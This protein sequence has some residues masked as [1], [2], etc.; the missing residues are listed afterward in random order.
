MKRVVLLILFL[1]G[2]L[3]LGPGSEA[4]DRTQPDEASSLPSAE[5]PAEP[6]VDRGDP[7]GEP[8][9]PG[10][11]HGDGGST[12]LAS[13]PPLSL[14]GQGFLARSLT[15]DAGDP[16]DDISR[17]VPAGGWWGKDDPD[18]GVW[19]LRDLR[20]GIGFTID[21]DIFMIAFGLGFGRGGPLELAPLV[22]LGISDDELLVAP[23][24]N[25]VYGFDLTE[26]SGDRDVQRLTPYV[27]GGVGMTYLEKERPGGR[28]D[29]DTGLLFDFGFGVDY[30]V[31]DKLSVGTSILFNLLPAE[32]S[33]EHFFVSWQLLSLRVAF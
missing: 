31:G 2:G 1:A 20:S 29:A 22:Q 3:L 12:L 15:Q 11:G 6:A 26:L 19:A 24:L 7:G 23:A 10:D 32:L 9:A 21:P 17:P 18:D 25:V 16:I 4:S 13:L 14:K 8:S 33:D 28:D 30:E 27:Q 5:D